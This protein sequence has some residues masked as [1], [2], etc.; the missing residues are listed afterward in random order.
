MRHT[1]QG[2]LALTAVRP[3]IS[4]PEYQAATPC[5]YTCNSGEQHLSP[6]VTCWAAPTSEEADINAIL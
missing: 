4:K 1:P 5:S 3:Y 2:N 6:Y